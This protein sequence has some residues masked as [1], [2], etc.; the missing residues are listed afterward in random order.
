MI[1]GG[2]IAA[3][4]IVF[5]QYTL[6]FLGREGGSLPLAMAAIV[7]LAV[8]N[9][10]GV[11]P[12]SRLL[13]V[14]VVLKVA[15]LALLIAAGLLVPVEPAA[16]AAAVAPSSTFL[17]IAF[18]S[19][20]IA[21]MFS[22]G[23]WQS[24]NYVAEEMERPQRDLPVAMITGIMVVVAVYLLI[25]V[26]YLKALGHGGLAATQTPA[27][28]TAGALLGSFGDRAVALAIAISTFGFLDLRFLAP[29]RVY[30]AMAADGVFFPAVAKLHPK[31]QSPHVAIAIQTVWALG[32]VLTGTYAQLVDYVVFADWIF[33]GLAGAAVF[34][35]RRRIPLADRPA[36]TFSTPGYPLVPALFVGAAALVLASVLW[37]SPKPSLIG[38]ALLAT[39][40][41]A[42]LYWRRRRVRT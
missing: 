4:A 10:F 15:A 12:G 8:V 32:L 18:G 36:G 2:A 37:S 17:P 6:A 25:N 21:I 39:G 3:V 9:Y 33:F 29:T 7:V 14:F 23:G 42:Y 28:D 13:N 34:V 27:S 31:H 20:L 41:P 30:Y 40:V 22:Y 26:V 24:L 38:A 35:F 16:S 19:A 11:K 5:A 1:E